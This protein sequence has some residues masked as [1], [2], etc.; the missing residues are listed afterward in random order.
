MSS[1]LRK[2]GL[3]DNIASSVMICALFGGEAAMI[4]VDTPSLPINAVAFILNCVTI[5]I[6]VIAGGIVGFFIGIHSKFSRR[7][8][9]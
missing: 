6:G 5:P 7:T 2:F 8:K 3:S 1:D 9:K 4:P